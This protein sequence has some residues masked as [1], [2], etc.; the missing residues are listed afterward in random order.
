MS[1]G[2]ANPGTVEGHFGDQLFTPRLCGPRISKLAETRGGS[3]GSGT[4]RV[5]SGSAHDD[6]PEQTDNEGNER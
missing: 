3:P 2:I 1:G 4:G 5:L 6:K